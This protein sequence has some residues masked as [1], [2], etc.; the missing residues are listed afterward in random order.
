M[1]DILYKLCKET[2][3][4]CCNDVLSITLMNNYWENTI[5]NKKY[6][7][8]L[9][10]YNKFFIPISSKC[11][12]SKKDIKELLSITKVENPELPFPKKLKQNQKL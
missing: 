8:L 11:I 10:F 9:K 3:A 4:S 7:K 6:I 1:K 12:S 2:G 5:T